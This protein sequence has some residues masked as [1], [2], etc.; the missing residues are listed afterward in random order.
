MCHKIS[1]LKS[2]PIYT[3]EKHNIIKQLIH[4]FKVMIDLLLVTV[5]Y[6]K[7]SIRDNSLVIS[8]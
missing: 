5:Y 2:H 8:Y 6:Y 4:S 3:Q 1:L 7:L